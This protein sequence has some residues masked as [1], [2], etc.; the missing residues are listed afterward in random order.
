MQS[1]GIGVRSDVTPWLFTELEGLHRLT[2]HPQG[3]ATAAEASYAF[4]AR[5]TMHY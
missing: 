3:A 5:V 4:F 2:T 1:L